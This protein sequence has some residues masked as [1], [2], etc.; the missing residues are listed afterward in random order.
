MDELNNIWNADDELNEEQLLDYVN[1]KSTD[2]DAHF[3]ERRMA[4]S[5]L[6]NDGIEGLK[7]F[8]S[9]E[10]I[11][12]CVQQVNENLHLQ[13]ANKKLKANRGIK[14]LS[15]EIIAVLVVI[16]LCNNIN[17]IR[18]CIALQELQD[19]NLPTVLLWQ[20]LKYSALK[21]LRNCCHFL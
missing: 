12:T 11:N 10:K 5:D 20:C 4:A 16:L 17:I 13:L 18:L 9:S 7:Q 21:F 19:L 1:G 3:I 14:N 6:V 15:W 8:S 2:E